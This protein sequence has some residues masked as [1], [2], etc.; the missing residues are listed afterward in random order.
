MDEIT[1][2][3]DPRNERS[4]RVLE[5]FGFVVTKFEE[6]TLEIAGE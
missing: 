5:K 6:R 4:L 2:D 1:A 3:V